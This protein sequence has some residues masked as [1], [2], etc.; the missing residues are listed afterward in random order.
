M[1]WLHNLPYKG[2]SSDEYE[3]LLLDL[4]SSTKITKA[5]R[6]TLTRLLLSVGVFACNRQI[7]AYICNMSGQNTLIIIILIINGILS[8]RSIIQT[9]NYILFAPQ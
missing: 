2:K 8:L 7:C 6:G 5:A 4:E 9:A 1:N 3:S